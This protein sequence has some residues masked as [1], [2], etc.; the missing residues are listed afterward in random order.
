MI[1]LNTEPEKTNTSGNSSKLLL[2]KSGGTEIEIVEESAVFDKVLPRRRMTVKEAI[3][4]DIDHNSMVQ[5]FIA[6]DS[7]NSEETKS[8]GMIFVDV[9]DLV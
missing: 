2:D 9:P 6:D 1:F 5:S 8:V 3:M 7:Q 4:S